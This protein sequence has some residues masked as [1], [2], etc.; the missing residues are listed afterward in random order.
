MGASEG[1]R[2]GHY[3]LVSQIGRGGFAE[4]YLGEHIHLG[5]TAAIKVLDSSFIN[6]DE[7]ELFLR[8]ARTIANLQHPN[9]L[10]I[11]DFGIS[12]SIGRGESHIPYLVMDYAPHGTLRQRHP[13]G[14][15]V[16]LATVQSYVK[17]VAA[18]LQW[19]HDHKVIHRD[20]K[21]ENLLVGRSGEILL[22]DFGIALISQSSRYQSTRDMA[23]TVAYMAPEQINAHP[24]PESDQYSLGIVVYE[25]LS[26]DRPFHGSFTEIAVKHSVVPPPSLLEKVPTLS[27]AVEQAVMRALAKDPKE[28]FTRVIDFAQTL[29]DVTLP[30]N[31][32]IGKPIVPTLLEESPSKD[33]PARPDVTIS[34]PITSLPSSDSMLALSMW[35]DAAEGKNERGMEPPSSQQAEQLTRR[36][37]PGTSTSNESGTNVRFSS[38]TPMIPAT[39]S[40]LATRPA[41]VSRFASAL[42]HVYTHLA[43]RLISAPVAAWA[44]LIHN[45]QSQLGSLRTVYRQH[46]AGVRGVTWSPDSTYLA[47]VGNDGTIQVWS[48]STGQRTSLYQGHSKVVHAISWSPEGKYLVTTSADKA[49]VLRISST[50]Q[51]R[52]IYQ[53]HSDQ[54]YTVAWSPDGKRL[55][56]AG[57]DRT[58]HMWDAITREDLLPPYEGHEDWVRA[59]AWSPNGKYIATA[60]NDKTVQIW[61]AATGKMHSTYTDHTDWVRAVTWSPDSAYL[62][63][64][65]NDSTV[66]IW[67]IGTG[68][69]HGI[70][71]GHRDCWL[72]A[73]LAVAWSPTGKYVASAGEDQTVRV[74]E[75]SSR[76]DVFIYRGHEGPINAIAWSS[77][78]KYVA[79]ASND[80]TVHVWWCV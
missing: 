23:G 45:E 27:P 22:S 11:L 63:T 52:L 29:E 51:K 60:S 7:T 49:V 57:A 36:F 35:T 12:D 25:W 58:V 15:Q 9:I 44:S 65:G 37:P 2:P 55:V 48:A 64:A 39:R 21:P 38:S 42:R 24:R 74:W 56:S 14:T 18:A 71:R 61:D 73:V 77:D 67:N 41:I 31:L 54:V 28:R 30:G 80:K 79:T 70:Y 6:P 8:E 76:K 59:A 32:L 13:Q 75:W 43:H 33:K 34:R 40:P 1:Q 62:A 26:G 47:T 3:R 5:T 20:V 50:D 17:Q 19:A 53:G 78:G 66:Q 46:R 10:R 68:Q 72:G 69:Q 16:P 4:V